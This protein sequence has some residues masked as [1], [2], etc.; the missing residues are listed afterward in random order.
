M[1][2][3][4]LLKLYFIFKFS[5]FFFSLPPELKQCAKKWSFTTNCDKTTLKRL[6]AGYM[7]KKL[8]GHFLTRDFN[9]R[10]KRKK[11]SLKIEYNY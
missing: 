5:F 2:L 1:S 8:N 3:Y 6:R 7:K 4:Y 10:V 9:S 11:M